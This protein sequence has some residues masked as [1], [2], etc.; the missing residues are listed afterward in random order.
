MMQVNDRPEGR[1][2]AREC[3]SGGGETLSCCGSGLQKL[4]SPQLFRALADP[5]RLSLLVRLAD[6]GRPCTVGQ[7]AEGSGVDLSVVSRH[8]A[9]L[10]EAGVITCE[11]QGKEVWCTV[12]AGAVARILRDLADALE[13]CCP[14][15]DCAPISS[16]VSTPP[17]ARRT[18]PLQA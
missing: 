16:D 8:L 5:R 4:L 1:P 18:A 14:D 9:T 10:R 12:Q 13:T 7:L 17:A 15:G 3:E 6:E 2:S 11:K